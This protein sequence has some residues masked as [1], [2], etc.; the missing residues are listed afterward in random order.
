MLKND[1]IVKMGIY[2]SGASVRV[3]AECD[4]ITQDNGHKDEAIYLTEISVM[5]DPRTPMTDKEISKWSESI[6]Q[7]FKD[8][9]F[10][11]KAKDRAE[12]D[13]FIAY[14]QKN[15]TVIRDLVEI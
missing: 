13:T 4:L 1:T 14:N 5:R 2:S 8:N 3:I 11:F 9:R 7:N 6:K 12:A 10:G 15:W